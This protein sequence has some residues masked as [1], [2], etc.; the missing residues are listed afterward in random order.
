M[1]MR[2]ERTIAERE[3]A[4]DPRV[5]AVLHA[6]QQ[7]LPKPIAWDRAINGTAPILIL[8]TAPEG[9]IPADELDPRASIAA[10]LDNVSAMEGYQA[11]PERI[12]QAVRAWN[13]AARVSGIRR[14]V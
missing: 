11:T 2:G 12:E 5:R 6:L 1:A 7:W 13:R 9:T 14:R 10:A 4:L 8:E 3:A